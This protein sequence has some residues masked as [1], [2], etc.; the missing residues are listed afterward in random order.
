ME[1]SLPHISRVELS[2]EAHA[3]VSAQMQSC[4]GYIASKFAEK[5]D[6]GVS[7]VRSSVGK[8]MRG[9]EEGKV[10]MIERYLE[11]GW[12]KYINNDGTLDPKGLNHVNQGLMEPLVHFSYEHTDR[13]LLLLDVQGFGEILTEPEIA[14]INNGEEGLYCFRNCGKPAF[15]KFFG[16]HKCN[17][18]CERLKLSLVDCSIFS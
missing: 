15:L 7:Y 16:A 3:R 11:G 14:S 8:F 13:K 1:D 2:V 9:S 18:Y 6:V 17:V 5:L 12:V 4:A 10:I